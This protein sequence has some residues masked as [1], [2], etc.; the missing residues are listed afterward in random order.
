MINDVTLLG[1]LVKNAIFKPMGENGLLL[2]TVAINEKR[3][4]E[5]HVEF[6]PI[7]WFTK[8]TKAQEYLTKGTQVLVKGKLQS[9]SYETDDG[10]KRNETSV[11]AFKVNWF[12]AKQ[13]EQDF[14]F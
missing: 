3:G 6:V 9:R 2:F 11:V 5:E 14:N 4:D 8:F 13:Q 12:R 1:N 7:K 10:Q